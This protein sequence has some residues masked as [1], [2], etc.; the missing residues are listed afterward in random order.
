MKESREENKAFVKVCIKKGVT[1]INN[2]TFW[3]CILHNTARDASKWYVSN[4]LF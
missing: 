1:K 2:C 4:H 3:L